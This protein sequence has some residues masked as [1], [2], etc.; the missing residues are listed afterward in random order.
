MTK[1]E[2]TL[3][4]SPERFL[5]GLPETEGWNTETNQISSMRCTTMW[6]KIYNR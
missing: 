1:E 5:L 3:L 6:M 2:T 4:S